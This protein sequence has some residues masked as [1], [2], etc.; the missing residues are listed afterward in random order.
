M[1]YSAADYSIFKFPANPWDCVGYPIAAFHKVSHILRSRLRSVCATLK[2]VTDRVCAAKTLVTGRLDDF[3]SQYKTEA[4]LRVAHFSKTIPAFITDA[5]E[6]F[7]SIA[8]YILSNVFAFVT[9]LIGRSMDCVAD[10]VGSFYASSSKYPL[11]WAEPATHAS[12][13]RT[14][15]VSPSSAHGSAHPIASS[16]SKKKAL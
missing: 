11:S 4:N 10:R 5:F 15:V 1:S 9:I 3:A 7:V 6:T 2:P 13:S 16:K 8:V 12:P 14:P